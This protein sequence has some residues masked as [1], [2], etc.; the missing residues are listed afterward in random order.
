MLITA[1]EQVPEYEGSFYK[2]ERHGYGVFTL[3]EGTDM[4]GNS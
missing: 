2:N 3:K 4:K 1:V